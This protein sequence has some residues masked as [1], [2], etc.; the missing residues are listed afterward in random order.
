MES[1]ERRGD[2]RSTDRRSEVAGVSSA[3]ESLFLF[4]Q[5]RWRVGPTPPPCVPPGSRALR[6]TRVSGGFRPDVWQQVVL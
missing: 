1:T 5:Y 4:L 3:A 6:S 2:E